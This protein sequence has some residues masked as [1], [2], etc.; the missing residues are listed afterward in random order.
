MRSLRTIA[1]VAAAALA[2]G[3]S[4]CGGD[5]S[6]TSGSTSGSRG[7]GGKTTIKLGLSAINA[8]H[9]WV[10]IAR[11]EKLMEP[12]GIDFQPVV[13]QGGAAQVLP[14]VLGGSTQFGIASAQQTMIAY[15]KD[16][17]LKMILN[18]MNGSPLSV[19][20]KK[21][22]SSVQ[23]LKGKIISVNSAG[24][25]EDYHS[26]TA[27]LEHNGIKPSEVKFVTGGATSARV[28]ALLSGA[29]DVVLCSPPDVD[30][31]TAAGATVIGQANDIPKLQKS[32]SYVIVGTTDWLKANGDAATRF[33]QGYRAT[34]EFM[35]DPAN[36]AAVVADITK[37]LS[38][39][40]AAA[41]KA[42]DYWINGFA[43]DSDRSGAVHEANLQQTLQNAKDSDVK[44]L[45]NVDPAKLKELYDNS[46]AE[47]AAKTGAQPTASAT[48]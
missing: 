36:H 24:S 30:R 11:D 5:S 29:V 32:A 34:Q 45:T 7:P 26:A 6:Q 25:S 17:N 19:V 18:P 2:L 8:S 4:A 27:F 21:G 48:S 31:L 40:T 3:L 47:A 46:Y 9:L 23:D 38:V 10:A 41:E 15:Q 33:A 44:A 35:H 22:I 37:T 39:D 1:V 43:K 20:A 12:Y 16:Q 14:A 28:S 42:Y 13:F